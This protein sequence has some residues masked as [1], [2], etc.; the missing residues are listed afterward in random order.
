[1]REIRIFEMEYDEPAQTWQLTQPMQ[2]RVSEGELWLTIDGDAGDYWLREGE[3]LTLGG[4]T[5]ARI[6][7]GRSGARFVVALG[8]ASASVRAAE[9][10]RVALKLA[11]A[12][13]DWALR[14]GW[15]TRSAS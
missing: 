6:S 11:G 8:G 5:S 12:L 4:R 14:G 3:T 9:A 1:M 7:A 13:R 10:R 2:L 15:R